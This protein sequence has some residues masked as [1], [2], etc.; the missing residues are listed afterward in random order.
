M[1]PE[2]DLSEGAFPDE[3]HEFVVFKGRGRQLVVLLDVGF[4][5]LYQS[6][7]LLEYSLV[8]LC[9]PLYVV[10]RG[11]STAMQV[12]RVGVAIPRQTSR[13]TATTHSIADPEMTQTGADAHVEADAS[14]TSTTGNAPRLVNDVVMRMATSR[15]PPNAAR[16]QVLIA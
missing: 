1:D 12:A 2:G 4:D 11:D 10:I 13:Y 8:D 3:L 9:C 16:F 14:G 7:P 5:E 15:V 6:I